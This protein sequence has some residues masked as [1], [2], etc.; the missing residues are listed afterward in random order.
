MT[1]TDQQWRPAGPGEVWVLTHRV[2]QPGWGGHTSEHVGVFLDPR[3]AIHE[4]ADLVRPLWPQERHRATSDRGRPPLPETPPEDDAAVVA[5]FFAN[6]GSDENRV[7]FTTFALTLHV[8]DATQAPPGPEYILVEAYQEFFCVCGNASHV[9]GFSVCDRNGVV[10]HEGPTAGWDGHTLC[11]GC[12]RIIV[13]DTG[14]VV[15]RLRACRHCQAWVALLEHP[16]TATNIGDRGD[17]VW[18]HVD[19]GRSVNCPDGTTHAEPADDAGRQ[20]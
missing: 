13:N 8:I 20:P 14:L 11:C 2:R 10:L 5:L 15:D 6:P 3:A 18:Q 9:E 7:G 17:P 16:D 19:K 1:V 12:G 4:L